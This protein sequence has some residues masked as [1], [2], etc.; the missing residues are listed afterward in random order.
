M[1]RRPHGTRHILHRPAVEDS[2]RWDHP[3]RE[4]FDLIEHRPV[5]SAADPEALEN[6]LLM[7]GPDT[8]KDVHTGDW[9][10]GNLHRISN[11]DGCLLALRRRIHQVNIRPT[12]GRTEPMVW[13]VPI[14]RVQGWQQGVSVWNLKTGKP[15]KDRRLC[16]Y[17]DRVFG[18]QSHLRITKCQ[19]SSNNARPCQKDRYVCDNESLK[20]RGVME[21][22]K[23]IDSEEPKNVSRCSARTGLKLNV[24]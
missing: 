18:W 11:L 19:Y 10:S 9:P 21:G 8:H 17:M 5:G 20:R 15:R 16:V 6:E 4:Y 1:T 24:L 3:E 13:M 22:E 7:Q 12:V 2:P 14:I 23:T